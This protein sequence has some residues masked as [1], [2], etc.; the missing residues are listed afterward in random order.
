MGS[1]V[2]DAQEFPPALQ[3][4]KIVDTDLVGVHAHTLPAC[5]ALVDLTLRDASLK[6]NNAYVYLDRNLSVVP[7]NICELAQLQSSHLSTESADVAPV[8]LKWVSELTSLQHLSMHF[9]HGRGDILQH[10]S[11]LTKLTY[12]DISGFDAMDEA[13]LLYVDIEWHKLREL[14]KL[15]IETK[16][17]CLDHTVSGLLL[18]PK[19][20]SVSFADSTVHGPDA[21]SSF[22]ALIYKFARLRPQVKL[23]FSAGDLVG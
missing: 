9:D 10:V 1:H 22:A 19:L 5:T 2:L 3:H 8:E 17:L 18:L 13:Y 16:R 7:V 23:V 4:L 14:R 6:G 11:L 15:L 20:Q 21:T 12:L